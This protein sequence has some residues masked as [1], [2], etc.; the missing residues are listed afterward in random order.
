MARP[1]AAPYKSLLCLLGSI[2]LLGYGSRPTATQDASGAGA[3]ERERACLEAAAELQRLIEE[4]LPAAGV[5]DPRVCAAIAATPRHCF[6]PAEQRAVAYEDLALPIGAGQSISPP[7][8]VAQMTAALAV[9]PTDRVLEIGTGSGYQAA[10]LSRLAAEVYSIEIHA[11]LAE[12]A[13]QTLQRLGLVNVHVR[14]GDGYAGWPEAAPFTKIIVTCSPDHVPQPLLD[15]LADGGQLLIPLGGRFQQSFHRLTKQGDVVT[16]E[17]LAATMFVPMTGQ[18][19]AARTTPDSDSHELF[20]SSFE[21]TGDADAPAGWYFLR[22]ARRVELPD[23][24]DGAAAL[25]CE[26]EIPGRPAQAQQALKVDGSAQAELELRAWV[27]GANVEPGQSLAERPALVVA[28]FDAERTSVGERI[29]PAPL[30]TYDWTEVRETLAAPQAARMA[31]VWVGLFGA[32][33]RAEFDG[34]QFGPPH[35][36]PASPGSP[37]APVDLP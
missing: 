35:A 8:I 37:G 32:T 10:V 29:I 36:A 19:E 22:Q 18:A 30:G 13:A 20:N 23:A 7:S 15:Q 33:G 24:A 14:A 28:F 11:P 12:R 6:V 5:T 27:R 9:Q 1:V 21:T 26:N 2:A 25:V 4:A 3:Q 34:L 16:E 17:V 31:I